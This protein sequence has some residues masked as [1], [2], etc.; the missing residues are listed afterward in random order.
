M[1]K[2]RQC[3]NVVFIVAVAPVSVFSEAEKSESAA[4]TENVLF[5]PVRRRIIVLMGK[6]T[7]L[8][9]IRLMDPDPAKRCAYQIQHY[10]PT[11]PHK[12]IGRCI[13]MKDGFIRLWETE[14][15]ELELLVALL[16]VHDSEQCATDL[17][18]AYWKHHHIEPDYDLVAG[19]V[20]IAMQNTAAERKRWRI[21]EAKRKSIAKERNA[22]RFEA[23]TGR[24][25]LEYLAKHGPSKADDVG[26]GIRH[27]I[28]AVRRQLQ[29][30]AK[31]GKVQRVS[32]GVYGLPDV[33][34]QPNA[35]R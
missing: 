17:L 21:K 5:A 25:I 15:N 16:Q 33:A 12:V 30:M 13:R 10:A 22:S 20:G 3:L 1:R 9:G 18:V 6:S 8:L 11:I 27:S 7:T 19:V 26:W 24:E 29:R 31:C 34:G 14:G 35:T 28:V 23:Q 4:T 32:R 2:V